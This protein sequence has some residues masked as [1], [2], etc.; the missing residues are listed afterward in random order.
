[1]IPPELR[2][3]LRHMLSLQSQKPS[4]PDS[5]EFATWRE[6]VAD[7]LDALACVLIFEEDRA[8]A[9]TEAAVARRQ[10]AEI[11]RR[12]SNVA[13]ERNDSRSGH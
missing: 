12:V 11:R 1:M 9:R 10:A 3:A 2:Y 13:I 5:F 8:Q 7:A 6:N 4:T